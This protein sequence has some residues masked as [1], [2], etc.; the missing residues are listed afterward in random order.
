MKSSIKQFKSAVRP[1]ISEIFFTCDSEIWAKVERRYLKEIVN[2]LTDFDKSA[3]S[4]SEFEVFTKLHGRLE[5]ELISIYREGLLS[6]AGK[7]VLCLIVGKI[8]EKN[9][10]FDASGRPKHWDNSLTIDETYDDAC[11]K[12]NFITTPT[13]VFNFLLDPGFR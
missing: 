13:S 4:F 9:F 7:S 8:F 6:E 10:R 12:V 11:Q 3:V 5:D 2:I 1:I